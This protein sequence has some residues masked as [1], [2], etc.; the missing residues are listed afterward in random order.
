V[1]VKVALEVSTSVESAPEETPSFETSLALLQQIVARLED[2]GSGLEA[3]LAE[4]EQG[5]RLLR[6]CYRQL[7]DAEQKIEQLVKFSETGEAI[8]TDFDATAT[9]G[10]P[11]GKRRA[12]S[13]RR[14]EAS[15]PRSAG[16][17]LG[18]E[19]EDAEG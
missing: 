11:A 14:T 17:Q 15:P 16:G 6:E 13:T 4:F 19:D 18:F 8:L 9:A 5:V 7:D 2:G 3:S 1:K 12:K 10:Q